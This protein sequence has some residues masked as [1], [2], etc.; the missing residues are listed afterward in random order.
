[1]AKDADNKPGR[2]PKYEV[3]IEG[4]AYAWDEETI[5]V[6]ELREL[7]HLPADTPVIEVDLKTNAERTLDE[8]E[9]VQLR[10]GQGFGRKVSFKRG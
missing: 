3:N 6:P 10:P 9:V 4:T 1:M 2:G 5:T 7:G 8:D